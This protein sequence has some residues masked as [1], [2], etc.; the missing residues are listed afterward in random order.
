MLNWFKFAVE[1]K[2]ITLFEYGSF[3]NWEKIDEGGFGA[4]FSA[5]SKNTD[6][7]IALK[8]LHNSPTST[9]EFA[10]E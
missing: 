4:V 5:Y 1:H 2:Y 6:E 10:G 9:Q 8:R 3:G 7:I